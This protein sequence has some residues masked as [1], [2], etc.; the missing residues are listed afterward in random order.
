[1]SEFCLGQNSFQLVIIRYQHLRLYA[2]KWCRPQ[3]IWAL[4]TVD[5]GE[6]PFMYKISNCGPRNDPWGIPHVNVQKSQSSPS[7]K[8][9]CF[10][11][12]RY[13]LLTFGTLSFWKRI[14]WFMVSKAFFRSR[15]NNTL[16]YL[17]LASTFIYK[18]VFVSTLN[19][20]TSQLWENKNVNSCKWSPNSALCVISP[21]IFFS[22]TM[23]WC[24][25]RG[26]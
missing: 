15:K 1:M 23:S 18:T 4:S 12:V 24:Q 7:T 8:V 17:H 13:D 6:R 3:T 10:C 25:W 5:I 11:P 22:G 16:N 2:L 19:Q 20:T 21:W 14:E 26:R 9:F